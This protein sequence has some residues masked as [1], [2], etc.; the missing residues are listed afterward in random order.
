MTSFP[1]PPL[2]ARLSEFISIPNVEEAGFV[3]LRKR[4]PF[5]LG[6][7]YQKAQGIYKHYLQPCGLTPK[8]LL[9]LE[10]LFE[11]ESLSAG[12]LGKRLVLDNATLSGIL[13]RLAESGWLTKSPDD[14]GTGV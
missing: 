3:I 7:A 2:H 9:V 10:A 14:V 8:Q 12:D 4:H 5:L 6:K 13:G 11:E 1:F